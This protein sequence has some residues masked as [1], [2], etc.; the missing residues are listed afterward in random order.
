MYPYVASFFGLQPPPDGRLTG[1]LRLD[2]F[3]ENALGFGL[4]RVRVISV[5]NFSTNDFY[6]SLPL[7]P[8]PRSTTRFLQVAQS[9]TQQLFTGLAILSAFGKN[10]SLPSSTEVT[11]RAVDKSGQINAEKTLELRNG[12]RFLGTLSEDLYFGP[13]F[14]QI[15]GHLEIEAYLEIIPFPFPV[16]IF[17]LFGDFSATFLSAIEGQ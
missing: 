13:D 14:E 1:H 16:F 7:I 6:S 8:F 3:H 12:E 17:A 9:N 4:P 5:I 2:L 10:Q 15:G 11:V